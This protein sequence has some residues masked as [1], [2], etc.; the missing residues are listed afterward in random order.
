MQRRHDI[1]H[2]PDRIKRKRVI[3]LWRLFAVILISLFVVGGAMWGLSRPGLRISKIE[4]SG[5]NVLGTDEITSFIRE[6]ISGKYFFLFPKDSIILYPKSRIENDLLDSFK[7]ILS[8]DVRTQG[9]STLSITINERKPYSLWCGETLPET[10]GKEDAPCYFMDEIGFLFAEAPRFSDSVYAKFYG[11][12]TVAN[13]STTSGIP[14]ALVPVGGTFLSSDVFGRI[15]LFR[16]L[17]LRLGVKV[18]R[19]VAMS[20]GD[21]A[22]TMDEGGEILFN[23]KQDPERLASDFESA[24]RAEWGDPY[25][26]AIRAKI[27]Y[28]DMRFDNKV[29]FKKKK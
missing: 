4:V 1:S 26:S 8:L 3:A 23:Q 7:R 20:A 11:P 12:L 14:R 5:N 24:F 13:G 18:H 22:F 25:D 19:A 17:L 6:E 2:S 15:N 21:L 29:F 16:G 27:L 10:R 9:L 28:A